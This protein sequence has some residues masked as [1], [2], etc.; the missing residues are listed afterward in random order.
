MDLFLHA[1][2]S[3]VER[4]GDPS[5]ASQQCSHRHQSVGLEQLTHATLDSTVES[6]LDYRPHAHL[7]VPRGIELVVRRSSSFS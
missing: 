3:G 7:T 5:D 2:A 1:D 6:V 4:S